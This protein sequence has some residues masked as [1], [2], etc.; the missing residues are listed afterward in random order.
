[1]SLEQ[2][3]ADVTEQPFGAGKEAGEQGSV[4]WLME[5]VGFVTASRFRDVL[6]FTKAGK[7]GAKRQ[8][9][10]WQVV[11]ERM[12]GKPVQHYDSAAMQH[13]TMHEPLAR[14]VYEARTGNFVSETGFHRHP[15]LPFVGGSPDGVIDDDG[16]FEAKCPFNTANHLQCFL[17]GMPEEHMAQVQGCMWITG[18]QW[19]DFVS[20]DP[21]MDERFDLY[22]QRIARDDEYIVNLD[23]EVRKFLGEVTEL[24]GKLMEGK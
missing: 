3:I 21:R 15:E 17:T 2:I 18:R 11:I 5:R 16:G 6:D 12:T 9:Y 7:P 24:H 1:M 8:A 10:L 14:Q 22:V 4:E 20:Y 19:W 13:G 23:R